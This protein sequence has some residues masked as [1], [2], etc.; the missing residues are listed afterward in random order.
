MDKLRFCEGTYQ[1]YQP[2]EVTSEYLYRKYTT[3]PSDAWI[4]TRVYP[5]FMSEAFDSS[6]GARCMRY[7]RMCAGGDERGS[8]PR[9]G[10]E[11]RV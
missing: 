4:L 1:Q 10:V 3:T 8:R 6:F 11:S 9:R 7:I 5:S 2:S